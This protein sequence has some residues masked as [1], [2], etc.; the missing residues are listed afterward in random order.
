MRG[1]VASIVARTEAA[2]P[3]GD[4]KLAMGKP[5]PAATHGEETHSENAQGEHAG[6][7]H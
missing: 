2:R 6:E 5:R 1:N 7:S 4:A 3:E